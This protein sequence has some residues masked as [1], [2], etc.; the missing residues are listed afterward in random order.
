MNLN[1]LIED[2][3]KKLEDAIE[4]KNHLIKLLHEEIDDFS[5]FSIGNIIVY[6]YDS[7][8]SPTYLIIVDEPI[9]G[10][11]TL[12]VPVRHHVYGY[13]NGGHPVLNMSGAVDI[14]EV[15][16]NKLKT[17]EVITVKELFEREKD[18]IYEDFKKRISSAEH[19][20]K[21]EKEKIESSNNRI[22]ELTEWIKKM[23]NIDF[24]SVFENSVNDYIE[25]KYQD[26]IKLRYKLDYSSC[27]SKVW[28]KI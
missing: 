25:N 6:K 20:I 18:K 5:K 22:K 10:D 12:K 17:V 27:G 3:R 23:N 11:E 26:N 4:E 28:W 15:Y 2:K 19:E 16:L 8:T 7:D 24:D 14:I 13:S 21:H 1:K 9:L